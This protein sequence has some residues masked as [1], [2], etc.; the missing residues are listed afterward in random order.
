M[1]QT[2]YTMERHSA[3]KRME[4]LSPATTHYCF[5]AGVSSTQRTNAVGCQGPPHC[6]HHTQGQT[7]FRGDVKPLEQ[8][9]KPTQSRQVTS[10][11]WQLGAR[12]QEVSLIS[13]Q[14]ALTR[15]EEAQELQCTEP[16]ATQR[17]QRTREVRLC[18]PEK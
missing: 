4:I 1:M 8:R 7:G 2:S 18:C 3:L 17:E 13:K 11:R 9:G 12:E 6:H 14:V 5:R 16:R 10:Q 15:P